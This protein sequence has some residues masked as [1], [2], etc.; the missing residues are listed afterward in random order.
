MGNTI[1]KEKHENEDEYVN[2]LVRLIDGGFLFPHGVYASEPSYKVSIVR[3]LMLERR[4]MP[5]YKGLEEYNA[6][7][8]PEK[9][10]DV[11]EKALGSQKTMT[12]R[13]AI[14]E[15][16]LHSLGNARSLKRSARS[17]SN[18]TPGNTHV[19][20]Q[21]NHAQAISTIYANAFECPIC[22]LY[23]PPNYNY[24]RCCAQPICSEC[25]VEI[26]RPDPHLP[27]VHAN[28]PT[29]ND[30][31]LISEP[32]KCPY[33]MT[34]R[35]GVVYVPNP[36]LSRFS[37]NAPYQIDPESHPLAKELEKLYI[38]ENE[39]PWVPNKNAKFVFDDP[40]VITTDYIRPDWQYNLEKARRRALRRAA[41]ATLLNSHL[42]E[43]S[44]NESHSDSVSSSENVIGL[45]A[46]RAN[47]Q[48]RTLSSRRNHYLANVEQLMVAEAIRQ[49]LE[50]AQQTTTAST[51]E[52]PSVEDANPIATTTSVTSNHSTE[53]VVSPDVR[54][55][56]EAVGNTRGPSSI[57]E[58]PHSQQNTGNTVPRVNHQTEVLPHDSPITVRTT[59][60]DT[61]GQFDLEQQQDLEELI[62]S[63]VA[64][65]N[66]FL[67]EPLD[68]TDSQDVRQGANFCSPT[69]SVCDD[70]VNSSNITK[71]PYPSVYEHAITSDDY[72]R[73]HQYG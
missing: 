47:S 44:P 4:L 40:R 63:P 6:G 48:R 68:L 49:S 23:Y 18:S 34:D 25:F 72:K 64:S 5:F 54:E 33:C 65:T 30:F 12:L 27:T 22:F 24:T 59:N 19:T 14:R 10:A 55:P 11:V 43:P 15:A 3:K 58:R 26:R 45:R 41:N 29:P 50:D 21:D 69:L 39:R 7:W 13:S 31:D 52:T 17:R 32:V 8:S 37:F 71:T 28:D 42:L 46:S 67:S 53:R 66:P 16:K 38:S 51:D 2:D 35:F 61:S 1:G 62:H 70:D 73:S 9:V 36:A 57:K 56:N 60:I 20:T